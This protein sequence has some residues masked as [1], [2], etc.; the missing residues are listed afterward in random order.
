[1]CVEVLPPRVALWPPHGLVVTHETPLWDRSIDFPDTP[2]TE[3]VPLDT[4]E[5]IWSYHDELLLYPSK[6]GYCYSVEW[7]G[8]GQAIP[9]PFRQHYYN[10]HR[11]RIRHAVI[12]I[13]WTDTNDNAGIRHPLYVTFFRVLK[14]PLRVR[15]YGQIAIP[16]GK[17]STIRAKAIH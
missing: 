8:H 9:V 17:F 4:Y 3:R 14:E 13:E 7:L 5:Q 1:M 10:T 2:H 16:P 12:A 11:V 6:D 15:S